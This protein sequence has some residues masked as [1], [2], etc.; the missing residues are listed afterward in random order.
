MEIA[1]EDAL[2]T[3]NRI[4]ESAMRVNNV[5][6]PLMS[7]KTREAFREILSDLSPEGITGTCP[8]LRLTNGG[9]CTSVSRGWTCRN[10]T[11]FLW[12][13][14]SDPSRNI[15]I[16]FTFHNHLTRWAYDCD[17]HRWGN[18]D[19]LGIIHL[20]KNTQF[21]GVLLFVSHLVLYKKWPI[22]RQCPR[23]QI[24]SGDYLSNTQN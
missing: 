6:W 19:S 14:S 15:Y 23:R 1:T 21:D 20:T 17:F 5:E 18:W 16:P 24:L 7:V 12:L 4:T 8:R 10:H 9:K 22:C 2:N 11:F 13:A 3:H